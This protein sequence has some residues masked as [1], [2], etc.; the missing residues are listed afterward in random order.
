MQDRIV[1]FAGLLRR[2][3]VRVSTAE[4]LDALRAVHLSGLSDRGFFKSA[5]RASMVKR[6]TDL[7]VYEELFDLFFSGVGDL[8]RA[9]APVPSA[10]AS[11]GELTEDELR[12]LLERLAELLRSGD[13]ELSDLAEALA[14]QDAG[15]LERILRELMES[16]KLPRTETNYVPPGASKQMLDMLGAADVAGE[17]QRILD[18]AR[19]QGAD[20]AEI[21][22]L[23]RYLEKRTKALAEMLKGLLRLD[24]E[25]EH[26]AE[27][28]QKDRERLLDKSF[29]YLSPTEIKLMREAVAA[30]ARKLKNA[31]AVRNRHAKRGRLDVKETIRRS[32][33]FGGVPFRIRFEDKRRE[34]PQVIVMCDVSD[35][36][37]NVS[38][39]MLQ[40]VHSLQDL[41]SRVRSYVFVADI[42]EVTRL[43][44]DNDIQSAIHKAINGDVVNVYAH[45]DFG[46]AFTQFQR[47]HIEAVDSRTTV[48]IL[49]DA[50]NNYNAAQEWTL[51]DLRERAKQVI[52]LN[53]ENRS[54]WGFGDSEMNVYG[55]HCD[56][57][58][59]CRNLRQLYKVVDILIAG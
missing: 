23:R 46:K 25:Q 45:S 49:G 57:V 14:M 32:M 10:D 44:K 12:A 50:R 42:A 6:T 33:E 40:F 37:R 58:E 5:L 30:L 56:F 24:R 47:N 48:I 29:Y 34:R 22:R 18:L 39:F 2:S 7:P 11:S 15:E 41:Y 13:L 3:G 27:E 4:T 21:D 20:D 36:V 52:W 31:M 43:F 38:R 16:G 8:V 51:R 55:K 54:T 35:S 9:N 17:F 19:E 1:E 26:R 53:P 28:R 59:E